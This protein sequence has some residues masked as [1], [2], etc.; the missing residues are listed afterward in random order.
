MREEHHWLHSELIQGLP[1][2]HETLCQKLL[3]YPQMV[4]L[5]KH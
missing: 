4:T 2:L 5:D 3:P 1:G